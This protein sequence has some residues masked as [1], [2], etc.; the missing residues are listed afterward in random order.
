[1]IVAVL[2]ARLGSTRLPGKVLKPLLGEP[3]L[4]RQ[5][6]RLQRAKSIDRLVVATSV[7]QRDDA[8]EA[9]CRGVG[10]ACSRGSV[11]DVLDRCFRAVVP[12]NPDLVMRLTGDC[13]LTDPD[14]IDGL[15]DFFW[16]G[17][18]DYASNTLKPT[19]PDG[20]DAEL[21]KFEC[22]EAAWREA[23]LRS[24]REHVT[25][26]IYKH[27]ERFKLGSYEN[28]RDLSSLR[29]TVDEPE[30]FALISKIYEALYL[31]HPEFTTHDVLELLRGSAELIS[32]NAGFERN[33]GYLRSLLRDTSGNH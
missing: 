26:F 11:N 13:P 19:W 20:L 8:I 32:M 17:R 10:V 21:M 1:M 22:M 30:D 29:W 9:F 25:P 24:E 3:M 5:L 23:T 14:V 33:E 28:D 16:A 2:Q 15:A 18:Y 27:P 31:R 4:G 12:H 7:D 6:E